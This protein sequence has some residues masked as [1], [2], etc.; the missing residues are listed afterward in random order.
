MAAA[1]FVQISP[2]TGNVERALQLAQ[3]DGI[4]VA[5]IALAWFPWQPE[6]M[7]NSGTRGIPAGVR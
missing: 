5:E 3:R 2:G 1:G 6:R 7:Q 4:S